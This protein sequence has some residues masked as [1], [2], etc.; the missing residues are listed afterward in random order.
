M[1]IGKKG[2]GSALASLFFQT[3][4]SNIAIIKKSRTHLRENSACSVDNNCGEDDPRLGPEEVGVLPLESRKHQRLANGL[5][6][7]GVADNRRYNTCMS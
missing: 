2:I 5:G 7:V 1:L 4:V 6:K 3:R